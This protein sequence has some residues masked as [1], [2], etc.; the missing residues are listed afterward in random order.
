MCARGVLAANLAQ[1][2]SMTD[3]PSIGK[4]SSSEITTVACKEA[5][6]RGPCGTRANNQ[7]IDIRHV[8]V[9]EFHHERSVLK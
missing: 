6:E 8:E 9:S 1:L 4:S 2:I 3:I 7:N 5:S